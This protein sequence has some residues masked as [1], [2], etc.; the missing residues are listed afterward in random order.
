MFYKNEIQL[1]KLKGSSK[2]FPMERIRDLYYSIKKYGVT[3]PLL[4]D[5]KYNIKLGNSRLFVL[6]L[7]RKKDNYLVPCIMYS[8][9]KRSEPI[10][11]NTKE[12]EKILGTTL[13]RIHGFFK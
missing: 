10:I 9:N 11:Q 2:N 13:K 12:L 1:K 5:E 6:R 4:I 8:L 7:L 3:T